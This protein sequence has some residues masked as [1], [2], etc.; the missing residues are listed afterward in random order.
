MLIESIYKVL[1]FVFPVDWES[2]TNNEKIESW[3]VQQKLVINNMYYILWKG[4]I[5]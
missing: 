5:I 3:S 4:H 1:L 2:V